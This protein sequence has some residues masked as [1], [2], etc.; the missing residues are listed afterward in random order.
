VPCADRRYVPTA[1]P[2]ECER[3][4]LNHLSLGS[5]NVFNERSESL[6][7]WRRVTSVSL[8]GALIMLAAPD[9][10]AAPTAP[11]TRTID[12][13]NTPI[14]GFARSLTV[15]VYRDVTSNEKRPLAVLIPQ[16]GARMDDAPYAR[17]AEVFV[18]LGY[19]VAIPHLTGVYN[20][21][22]EVPTYDVRMEPDLVADTAPFAVEVLATVADL[23]TAQGPSSVNHVV[24]GEGFGSL[25]ATRYAAL[26]A[27]GCKALVLV[28]AGFGA[29]RS[30]MSPMEDMR[31]SEAAFR[32]LGGKVVVPSLWLYAADNKRISEAAAK[33]LFNAYASE[34]STA[35]LV[36]LPAIAIDGDLLFSKAE[37]EATWA[38][39][40]S[41]YLHS[42]GTN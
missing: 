9:V 42:I 29:K 4:T 37:P 31:G 30:N 32:Q 34:N 24:I 28:S 26:R 25:V 10:R 2:V 38:E 14:R 19:V 15:T 11:S 17:Q 21:G 18:K 33:Q 12:L 41:A 5:V 16:L 27:P 23:S 7:W 1:L 3:G 6:E 20:D 40:V 36:M 39:P 35:R 8:L 22:V 13:S